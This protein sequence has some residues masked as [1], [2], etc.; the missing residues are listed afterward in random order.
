MAHFRKLQAGSPRFHGLFRRE[1]LVG[2]DLIRQRMLFNLLPVHFGGLRPG[3]VLSDSVFHRFI[4]RHLHTPMCIHISRDTLR[5][6][7]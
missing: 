3:G 6:H 1:V 5:I 4:V 7:Q 2:F